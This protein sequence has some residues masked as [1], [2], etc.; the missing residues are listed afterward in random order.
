MKEAHSL[1]GHYQVN[2]LALNNKECS[3]QYIEDEDGVEIYRLKI[4]S[5]KFKKRITLPLKYLE[6]VV[7]GVLLVRKLKPD[8]IHCHDFPALP[9]GYF[10]KIF[11]R[12]KLIY[13]S[14]EFREDSNV[15]QEYPKIVN[16]ITTKIEHFMAKN[17]DRIITVSPGIAELLKKR[18]NCRLPT[19][20]MNSPYKKNEN[21][22]PLFDVKKK[23]NIPVNDFIFTYIGGILPTRGFEL[24]LEA[25]LKVENPNVHL[26]LIGNEKF[27]DWL[28]KRFDDKLIG[29]NI[30]FIP[31]V[32][33]KEVIGLA[34]QADIGIHAIRGESLSHQYC[35]P[36]KLFEYIQAGLAL[37]M[38]DLP[39]L[40]KIITNYKVGLTFNDGD[41]NDLTEK[42]QTLVSNP[43]MI[44]E[45]KK[46]S[47]SVSSLLHWGYEEH[48]LLELYKELV[49]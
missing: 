10:S 39:E 25:Y 30:H 3:E 9:V 33:P 1:K 38:T 44:C 24:I 14:H 8:V 7:K 4:K 36:N 17:S 27:P 5:R 45:L 2:I 40:K 29:R 22:K 6:A 41:I 31:P 49:N 35:M 19:V 32:H 11:T 46:N 48:K 15:T 16:Y 23:F 20:I 42:L 28:S 26:L 37:L 43:S 13:D 47:K 18:I 34:S 12:S 21:V